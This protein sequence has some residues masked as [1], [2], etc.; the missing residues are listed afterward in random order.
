MAEQYKI[1]FDIYDEFETVLDGVVDSLNITDTMPSK[2]E[3]LPAV[4]HSYSVS[5]LDMNRNMAAP[6]K[7]QRDASGNATGRQHTQLHRGSFEITV[8]AETKENESTVHRT[9]KNHF[10]KYTK[11][12]WD[13]E[14]INPDIFNINVTDSNEVNIPDRFPTVYAHQF[15]LEVDFKRLEIEDVDAIEQTT[16]DVTIT[17]ST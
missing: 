4:V 16:E 6:T 1:R 10:Q 7:T 2:P 8:A 15:T 5:E 13:A 14:D 17:D 12:G 9:L 3:E 11:L